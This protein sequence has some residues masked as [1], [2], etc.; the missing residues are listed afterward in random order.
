MREPADDEDRPPQ[1]QSRVCIRKELL[2]S[3]TR[4][5][6]WA[7]TGMLTEGKCQAEGHKEV[8]RG[9]GRRS[10]QQTSGWRGSSRG[11]NLDPS[12]AVTPEIEY[13]SRKML[14]GQINALGIYSF[15]DLITVLP[16]PCP[17]KYT[18]YSPCRGVLS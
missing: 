2:W 1:K 17:Q 11:Q 4:A 10:G 8:V 9:V 13:H 7:P 18:L 5:A 3:Q 16:K 15:L 6:R 12:P 14:G